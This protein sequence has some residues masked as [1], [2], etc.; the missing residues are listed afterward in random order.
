MTR[1]LKINSLEYMLT[2]IELVDTESLNILILVVHRALVHY[3]EKK[4]ITKKIKKKYITFKIS[5]IEI[6]ILSF[7]KGITHC[8]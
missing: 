7:I 6:R 3:I 8:N 5:L 4:S 1:K 2:L